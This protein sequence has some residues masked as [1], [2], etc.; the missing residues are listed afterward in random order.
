MMKPLE[1]LQW[2]RRR[3][4]QVREAFRAGMTAFATSGEDPVAFYRACADY[5]VPAQ[6]RL[7]DQ[8]MRLANLIRSRVPASQA[9]DHEKIAALEVRLRDSDV[10]LRAFEAAAQDLRGRGGA[11][12]GGFEAAARTYIDFV[13]NVLGAR[14]HSLRHLTSTLL[15]EAD[16]SHI[17]GMTPELLAEEGELFE[18]V[19]A[20][21]PAGIDP[22]MVSTERPAKPA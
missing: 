7:I 8:D 11:A 10:A 22:A 4:L 20:T 13:V 12:R 3:K 16:W 1:V 14:S 15:N 18:K 21:A 17:T 19:R 9:E 5:L 2:E 6:R